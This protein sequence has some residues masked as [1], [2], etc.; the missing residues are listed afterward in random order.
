[1]LNGRQKG[2]FALAWALSSGACQSVLDLERYDFAGRD[3][4]PA[5]T[6][7]G[8]PLAPAPSPNDAQVPPNEAPVLP[9]VSPRDGTPSETTADA[10]AAPFAEPPTPLP[11]VGPPPT[12]P[13]LVGDVAVDSGYAGTLEGDER[14]GICIGGSVMVGVSFYYYATGPT[15]GLGF[16]APICGRFGDDPAAPLEW[17]RDDTAEAWLLSDELLGE[18]PPPSVEQSL[19]ELVCPAPLVVAGA[20]G[21]MDA[22]PTTYIIRDLTLECA[23]VYEVPASSQVLIDRGGT[24]LVASSAFSLSGIEPYSISCDEGNVATGSFESS[25]RWLDGFALS[26]ASLRWPRIAGDACS[27]GDACQSGVCDGSGS[28]AAGVP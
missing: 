9:P 15:A 19:G 13:L 24:T 14:R 2:C 11:P 28:C 4:G 20:R 3:A 21:S 7:T 26:C 22:T 23:P 5:A 17:S 16:L 12:R 18:P 27:A 25:G 6:Q 10:G 1:M 8:N